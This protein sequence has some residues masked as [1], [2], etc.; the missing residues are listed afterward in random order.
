MN[1]LLR[2]GFARLKKDKIFW[3]G[4]ILM[5]AVGVIFVIN[6]LTIQ[7]RTQI[8]ATLDGVLFSYVFFTGLVSA[9]FCSLFIGTEY[10]DGTIRNKLVVGHARSAIYLSNLVVGGLAGLLMNLAYVIA[11]CAVGIPLFGVPETG[12]SGIALLSLCSILMTFSFISIFTL[13]GMLIHNK[14]LV[15]VVSIIGALTLLVAGSYVGSRLDEPEYFE[16]A[17]F[18]FQGDG[19]V[20]ST[21]DESSDE[22]VENPM[23]LKGTERV[24]YQFIYD[25][26]PSGQAMQIY[27]FS[28]IHPW[29]L[30]LY[31]LLIAVLTTGGGLYFFRKKDIQ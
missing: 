15:A 16:G 30:L 24:V 18:V 25:F 12:A 17:N 6:D 4:M 27:M 2:A 31:S 21:A 3:A 29:S 23:Y 26:L 19:M 10:S 20:I 14:A 11:V 1:K 5:F 28:V 22:R 7:Q 13:L 8:P 9:A